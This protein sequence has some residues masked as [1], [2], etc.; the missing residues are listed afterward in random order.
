METYIFLKFTRHHWKLKIIKQSVFQ[1]IY[2]LQC[3]YDSPFHLT[4]YCLAKL[5]FDSKFLASLLPATTIGRISQS[6]ILSILLSGLTCTHIENASIIQILPKKK[7][8]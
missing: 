3:K 6:N 4:R 8:C 2:H 7:T 5:S 1:Y